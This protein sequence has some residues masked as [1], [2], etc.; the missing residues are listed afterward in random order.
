MLRGGA[1]DCVAETSDPVELSA[2]IEAKLRRVPVP[3]ENLLLD[4][5]TGLY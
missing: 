2:R 3:V 1:D 5:R 4:P